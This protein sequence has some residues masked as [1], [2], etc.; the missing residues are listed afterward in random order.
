MLRSVMPRENAASLHAEAWAKIYERIDRQLAPLGLAAIEALA[1]QAGYQILDVGCGAGQTLRQ[2]AERVSAGGRISLS[3][4]RTCRPRKPRTAGV[5]A[6]RH[7][8]ARES[9]GRTDPR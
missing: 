4:P 7:L 5:G 2:L 3:V 6:L 8:D 1:H 9:V